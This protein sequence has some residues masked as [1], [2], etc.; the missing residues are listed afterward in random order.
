[1]TESDAGEWV[2]DPE[3]IKAAL[4]DLFLNVKVRSKDEISDFTDD[5]LEEEREKLGDASLKALI[6]YVKTSIEILMNLKVEDYM[7]IKNQEKQAS[8]QNEAT[9]LSQSSSRMSVEPPQD[10]EEVIQKFEADI[11][12]HIRIEQQMK[13]HSESL[14]QKIED[15]DKEINKIK[16]EFEKI[17]D[18]YSRE[19]KLLNQVIDK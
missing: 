15:K 5:K 9:T 2:E 17:K 4:I 12:K 16:A 13:L 6:N 18:E 14:Q 7:T 8:K 19:K 10:Y 1:M 11:R 3:E